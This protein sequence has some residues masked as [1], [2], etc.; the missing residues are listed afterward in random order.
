MT[1]PSTT[2]SVRSTQIWDVSDSDFRRPP[3]SGD[4]TDLNVFKIEQ[5]R[6]LTLHTTLQFD[7]GRIW[8]TLWTDS[9][10]VQAVVPNHP[11]GDWGN[12]N[13]HPRRTNHEIFT[14]PHKAPLSVCSPET[15][16]PNVDL[17]LFISRLRQTREPCTAA[18]QDVSAVRVRN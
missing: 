17:R 13:L 11:V 3:G 10:F 12:L 14:L 1:V 6:P 5:E 9:G 4:V 8:R 7:Y 15:G 16:M 2:I 18:S